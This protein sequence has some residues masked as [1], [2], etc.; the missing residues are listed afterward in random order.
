MIAT[1]SRS[2]PVRPHETDTIEQPPGAEKQTNGERQSDPGYNRTGSITG[3]KERFYSRGS[4]RP[5]VATMF[6]WIS[7]VP[8]SIVLA[9]ERR[10]WYCSR[11]PSGVHLPSPPPPSWPYMPSIFIPVV[12]M[13]WF[14]SI[15]YILVADAS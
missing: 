4:P 14:S 15:E 5:R 9:T 10:Y 1:Q 11:P 8:P 6:F 13:R 3:V 2:P 7:V 12:A